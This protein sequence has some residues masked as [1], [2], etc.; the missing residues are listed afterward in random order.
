MALAHQM[1][2]AHNMALA[3]QMAL[4]YQGFSISPNRQIPRTT[5]DLSQ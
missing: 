1:A 5:P 4:A 3:H 2:L